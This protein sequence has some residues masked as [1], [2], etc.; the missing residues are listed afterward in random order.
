MYES[1]P[2]R[3]IFLIDNKSFYASVEAVARGYNPL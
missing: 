1:E 2:K 3:V